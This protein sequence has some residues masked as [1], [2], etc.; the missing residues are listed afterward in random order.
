M[1]VISTARLGGESL[2]SLLGVLLISQRANAIIYHEVPLRPQGT[3]GDCIGACAVAWEGRVL[4]TSGV[5]A[6]SAGGVREVYV[7]MRR[8]CAGGRDTPA[9]TAL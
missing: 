2:L 5:A 1:C 7:E 6:G 4:A 8:G 3:V 9:S